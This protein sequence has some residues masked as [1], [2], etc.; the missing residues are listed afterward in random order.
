MIL[1]LILY[2]LNIEV[3]NNKDLLYYWEKTQMAKDMLDVRHK[4][5]IRKKLTPP[6]ND[7]IVH[8]RLTTDIL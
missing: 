2:K 7:I 3:E 6:Q 1:K 5:S 4:K 8:N